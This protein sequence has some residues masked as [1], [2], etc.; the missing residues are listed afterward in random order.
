MLV[1]FQKIH[2]R[3]E[4]RRNRGRR[5]DWWWRWG[6]AEGNFRPSP[7]FHFRFRTLRWRPEDGSLVSAEEIVEVGDVCA[8][9][10]IG[11]GL[12]EIVRLHSA[13][14]FVRIIVDLIARPRT[15]L[16]GIDK[17]VNHFFQCKYIKYVGTVRCQFIR[18][19]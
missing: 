18:S 11:L 1:F 9:L 5:H 14:F 7:I 3:R 8:H 12:V 16:I 13:F 19:Y 4:R 17:L 2:L 6:R 10:V 15:N